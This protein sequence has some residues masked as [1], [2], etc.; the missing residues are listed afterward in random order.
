MNFKSYYFYSFS[1]MTFMNTLPL[2]FTKLIIKNFK[3]IFFIE[4]S[5]PA[6]INLKTIIS[7]CRVYKENVLKKLIENS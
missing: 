5:Y 3:N 2:R 6:V 1:R 7:L 4:F